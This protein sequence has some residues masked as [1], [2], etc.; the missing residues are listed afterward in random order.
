[1]ANWTLTM[2]NWSNRHNRMSPCNHN[3]VSHG[4]AWLWWLA[5]NWHNHMR[6]M[7]G[8][9]GNGA[10]V[11]PFHTLGRGTDGGVYIGSALSTALPGLEATATWP[12]STCT[13]LAAGQRAGPVP[14]VHGLACMLRCGPCHT[15]DRGVYIGP[16]LSTAWPVANSSSDAMSVL[17][18]MNAG[19][20]A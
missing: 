16:A 13:P 18:E 5:A 10:V 15:L 8:H 20:Y 17:D 14:T 7:P 11:W 4:Y 6:T 9:L 3:A 12:G 1:M 19:A 2:P